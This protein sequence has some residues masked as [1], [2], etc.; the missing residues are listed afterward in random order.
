MYE[1][2][3]A[4]PEASE[5]RSHGAQDSSP[6]P[7]PQ[8]QSDRSHPLCP[9]PRRTNPAAPIGDLAGERDVK[10]RHGGGRRA[11][12]LL[13]AADRDAGGDGGGVRAAAVPRPVRAPPH[14]AQQVPRRRVLPPLEVRARAPLVRE[15]PV[16][17]RHG[18]DAPDAEDP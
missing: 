17:A 12:G 13:E 4:A 18:A 3:R 16:R 2:S 1:L 14:P 5:H 6:N 7:S 8:I 15:V 10:V 9:T 11:A